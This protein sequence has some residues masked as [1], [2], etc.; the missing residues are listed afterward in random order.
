MAEE[1]QRPN[2]AKTTREHMAQAAR[3]KSES[4]H[5]TLMP[6]KMI[7]RM[8]TSLSEAGVDVPYSVIEWDIPVMEQRDYTEEDVSGA[9]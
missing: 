5:C 6:S 1:K 9:R 7:R 4:E 2:A 3:A 8:K